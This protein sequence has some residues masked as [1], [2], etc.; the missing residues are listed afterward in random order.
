MRNKEKHILLLRRTPQNVLCTHFKFLGT[1][2]YRISKLSTTLSSFLQ[3][4]IHRQHQCHL[5]RDGYAVLFLPPSFFYIP[6]TNARRCRPDLNAGIVSP[7]R[8]V[9]KPRFKIEANGAVGEFCRGRYPSLKFYGH[10]YSW[11]P[12]ANEISCSMPSRLVLQRLTFYQLQHA[13]VRIP[14]RV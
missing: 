3:I 12:T 5:V 11:E 10:C 13:Q 6:L 1:I 14:V 7:V 4:E 2:I 8:V 9:K